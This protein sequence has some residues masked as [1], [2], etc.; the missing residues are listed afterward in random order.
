MFGTNDNC[1][2]MAI[3]LQVVLMALSCN[4]VL[5]ADGLVYAPC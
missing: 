3:K 5:L 2:L 1:V 4:K